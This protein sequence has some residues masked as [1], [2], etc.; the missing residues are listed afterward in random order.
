MSLGREEG[1]GLCCLFIERGREEERTPG[2]ASMGRWLSS[3]AV[4]T[5]VTKGEIIG[6]G[7]NGRVEA[8]IIRDEER[9]CVCMAHGFDRWL[10]CAWSRAGAGVART[11]A[12]SSCSGAAR[13]LSVTRP[14][15][16][17]A[18]RLHAAREREKKGGEREERIE[19]E[20]TGGGGGWDFPRGA[21]GCR[22]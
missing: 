17:R 22:G 7:R 14:G 20:D 5:S 4:N 21:R 16:Q 18:R 3:Y 13:P 1:R 9:T 12:S 19:G 10:A 2:R 11:L 8:P 15:R 6:G